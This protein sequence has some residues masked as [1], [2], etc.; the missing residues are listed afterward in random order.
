MLITENK[1]I[2]TDLWRRRRGSSGGGG[3][4][5]GRGDKQN[6]LIC[7]AWTNPYLTTIH[8]PSSRGL[9]HSHFST[10]N[11]ILATPDKMCF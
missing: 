4:G 11:S 3:G 10:D 5:G 6:Y 2:K 9:Y 8:V 7:G 1:Y